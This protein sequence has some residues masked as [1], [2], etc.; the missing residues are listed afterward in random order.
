MTDLGR[1]TDAWDEPSDVGDSDVHPLSF[2]R[3]CGGSGSE[4]TASVPHFEASLAPARQRGQF[5]VSLP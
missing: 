4:A 2:D 5:F 1:R 3:A